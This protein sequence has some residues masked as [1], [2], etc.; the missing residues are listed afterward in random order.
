CF[1]ESFPG[2]HI[3]KVIE[4]ALVAS[5]AV[6]LR[7][8]GG[9]AKKPQGRQHPLLGGLARDVAALDTH[10]ITRQGKADRSDAGERWGRIAVRHEAVFRVS[11]VPE[12]PES[13]LLE[14][15]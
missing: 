9:I 4:E 8:L 1:L 3:Q 15:N 13:A 5:G 7:S 12:E 10:W 11:R 2:L 14:L 6:G